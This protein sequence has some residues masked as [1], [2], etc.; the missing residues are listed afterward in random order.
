MI[1]RATHCES[2][3]LLAIFAHPDDETFLAGGT[4]AKYAAQGWDVRVISA[5]YGENG[6]RGDYESL[7]TNEFANLRRNELQAACK[8][9]GIHP[10]MLLECAD[11]AV[12]T[13]CWNSAAKEIARI[14]R[15]LRPDVVITFGPDGISGHPDHVALSQI[16]TSAFWVASVY[17]SPRQAVTGT[18]PS[19]A[20]L[21]YVLRSA[22][23]PQS[24]VQKQ[25]TEPVLTTSIDIGEVGERK[26]QAIRS[27]HSQKH[28]HPTDP[29]AIQSILQAPEHFHRR[30]PRWEGRNL[31]SRLGQQ[32]SDTAVLS[33]EVEEATAVTD[34]LD[35][36]GR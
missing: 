19:P 30:F 20:S 31:E 8:A 4:L 28:L 15:R 17:R 12:A 22:S 9:L 25:A 32:P 5:T 10:P 2:P 7:S 11:R 13:I 14:I 33:K 35:G 27:Y 24:C 18:R 6:R 34:V 23:V 1:H 21:Y 3:R 29:A 26:L 36:G 16:V